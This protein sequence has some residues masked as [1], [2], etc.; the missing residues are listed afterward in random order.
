M[1]K[2]LANDEVVR[3]LST[4][5]EADKLPPAGGEEFLAEV[6]AKAMSIFVFRLAVVVGVLVIGLGGFV[7]YLV[8]TAPREPA[9]IVTPDDPGGES[10]ETQIPQ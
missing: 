10:V 5:F 7:G 3:R 1:S 8:A 9:S 4:A 2:E 6:R